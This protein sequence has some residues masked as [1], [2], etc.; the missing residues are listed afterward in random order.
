MSETNTTMPSEKMLF[1]NMVSMLA[2]TALQQMGKLIHPETGK[3]SAQLDAAQVTIDML[4]MLAAK[5]RG[6]LDKE[7]DKL[8]N[9]TLAALKMNFVESQAQAG[10]NGSADKQTKQ[11]E[12]SE[13]PVAGSK[14]EQTEPKSDAT[15]ADASKTPKYHKKYE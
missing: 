6:N 9:D 14:A 2:M 4:D 1:M 15:A 10:A 7:E 3:T 8:L 12:T 13:P 5:T 11:T